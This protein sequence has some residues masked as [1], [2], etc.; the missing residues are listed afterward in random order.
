ML[1]GRFAKL[2]HI[3]AYRLENAEEMQALDWASVLGEEHN[4]IFLEWPEKV[5]EA[6]LADTIPVL[7]EYVDEKRRTITFPEWQ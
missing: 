3:D 7:L 1:G 5:K 4:L 2:I 6:L